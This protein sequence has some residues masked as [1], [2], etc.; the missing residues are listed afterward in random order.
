MNFYWNVDS[1]S[2]GPEWGLRFYISYKLPGD[3]NADGP[4]T[5]LLSSEISR[6][7]KQGNVIE[8]GRKRG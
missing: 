8:S 6:E 5:T 1:E 4:W 7:I 2:L 3:A